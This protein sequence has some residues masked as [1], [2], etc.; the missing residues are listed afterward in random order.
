MRRA[1]RR[2][3][4]AQAT[5]TR[6]DPDPD[7]NPAASAPAAPAGPGGP[8]SSRASRRRCSSRSSTAGSSTI[9]AAR[10]PSPTAC[11]ASTPGPRTSATRRWY[12][13]VPAARAAAEAGARDRA[14]LA[15]RSAG[16]AATYASWRVRDRELGTHP[17]RGAPRGHASTRA[18][19]R[20]PPLSRVHAGPR[21]GGFRSWSARWPEVSPAPSW[22]RRRERAD[23]RG[24][25]LAGDRR[26]ATGPGQEATAQEAAAGCARASRRPS[27]SWASSARQRM[28]EQASPRRGR[29]SPSTRIQPI[30]LG[31]AGRDRRPE[32]PAPLDFTAGSAPVRTPSRAI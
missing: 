4:I 7:R 30:A 20:S 23:L 8:S 14:A 32:Q 17:A 28:A 31:G 21:R 25:R 1:L 15:R 16:P 27:A 3:M 9:S 13:F 19:T 24:A 10:N 2:A 5:T 26:R 6:R 22:W 18:P 29:S 12:C 11:W